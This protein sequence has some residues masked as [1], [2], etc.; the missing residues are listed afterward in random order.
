MNKKHYQTINETLYHQQMQNGL[1]VYLLK[2]E[3]FSKTYGL[4]ATNFGSVDTTFVPLYEDKMIKVPDGV[5]HFLEHKMFEMENG[6]ISDEFSKLG[7]STNAFTSSNRTAYLFSTGSNEVECTKLLLDFVQDIYLTEENIEKEKGIIAQEIKMYD[8]DPD[9]QNYFGAIQNLYHHHPFAIDIAG[10]VESVY[11][12]TKEDLTKCY[13]TFYHPSNMVLFIVGQI[14]PESLMKVIEENQNNKHFR[15]VDEVIRQKC[16]EPNSVKNKETIQK[17]D[18]FMPKLTMGIKV[19][20]I[21]TDSIQRVKREMAC[22]IILDYLFSKSSSL[23]NEWVNKGWINDTF[24]GYYIQERDYACIQIGGDT[25]FVDELKQAL[26]ELVESLPSTIIDESSFE[27]LKRKMMGSYIMGFNSIE[28]IANSFIRYY[29]EGFSSFELIDTLQT[30]NYDD[31]IETL[32]I[33]DINLSSYHIVMPN[34]F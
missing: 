27:R 28:T 2:K 23:Y 18:V 16:N 22:H 7:A 21:P 34:H 13:E 6:D 30:L 4:F 14:D 17:M 26:N 24:G 12:T 1:N 29:F 25:N 15:K 32:Q 8:D 19:N 9:W 3:G 5:A 20:N 33:F 31:I 10:T 11:S